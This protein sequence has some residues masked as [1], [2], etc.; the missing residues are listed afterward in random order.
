MNVWCVSMRESEGQS[1]S[2]GLLGLTDQ[3][4][5]AGQLLLPLQSLSGQPGLPQ[6]P[7]HLEWE[8]YC[9]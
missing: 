2:T 6:R 3:A 5:L 9:D 7:H 4:P 8:S 1:D